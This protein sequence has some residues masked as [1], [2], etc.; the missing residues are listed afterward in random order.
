MANIDVFRNLASQLSAWGL[1]DL[2]TVDAAGNPGGWLW[3]QIVTG[4]VT[5]KDVFQA[6]LEATNVWRDRFWGVLEMRK[7]AAAGVPI[8]PLTPGEMIEYEDRTRA[9]MKQ[10]NMPV[11]FYDQ[12][13]DIQKLAVEGFSPVDVQQRIVEGF[14]RWDAAPAEV[15][16]AFGDYFGV[17]GNAAF[18]AFVLN[19]DMVMANVGRMLSSA[20]IGGQGKIYGLDIT[21][22]GAERLVD[23]GQTGSSV[24]EGFRT[25]SN[26]SPLFNEA[27][28][29]EDFT[30]GKEGLAAVFGVDLGSGDITDQGAAGRM[31]QGR[32]RARQAAFSGGG[33]ALTSRQGVSGLGTLE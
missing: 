18:A 24:G 12:Q 11:S 6:N 19:P 30:A 15:K 7:Q 28:G 2:F 10:Y 25:L 1:G 26:L 4:Q 23:I 8:R 17:N 3:E 21:R 9:L 32:A 33:G 16:Q 13:N 29:E 31:L 14:G 27:V 20:E 22:Q 5:D